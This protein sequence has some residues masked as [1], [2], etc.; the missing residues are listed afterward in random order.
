MKGR[1]MNMALNKQ[2]EEAVIEEKVMEAEAECPQEEGA[3][4]ACN[5]P[6]KKWLQKRKAKK[7]AKKKE[8]KT[9]PQEI[10]SWVRTLLAAL[11]IA[12]LF[13]MYIGEPIRVDG[14]SMCNTLM[15]GE[16]VLASKLAYRF[17]DMQRG[18]VVICRY[19]N[20]MEGSVDLGAALSLDTYTLFVKRLVAL[21]GDTL[22]IRDGILYV[23]GQAVEDPEFMASKPSDFPLT[24]LGAD[25]YFVVGDNRGTSHDSRSFDVGPISGSAIMGK[26]KCVVWPLSEIRGVK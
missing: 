2:A 5:C 15:D 12:T 16:I 18:D 11:V 19:P 1:K 25:Q 6:M 3:Q 4:E 24:R 7:E 26:V 9:V 14:N 17:G 10:L 22:A 21:P 23:N 20:R 8:K 13:R